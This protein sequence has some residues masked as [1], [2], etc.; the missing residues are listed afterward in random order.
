MIVGLF[1]RLGVCFNF[2]KLLV[3]IT[4]N[5]AIVPLFFLLVKF[6][7]HKGFTFRN[8]HWMF[9]FVLFCFSLSFPFAFQFE[10]LLL[11]Y[12]QTHWDFPR[13]C[14]VYWWA[15]H[16]YCWFL[17][18]HFWFLAF[19]L[20]SFLHFHLLT[21][22]SH[23]SCMLPTFSARVLTVRIM[24]ILNFLS[25]HSKPCIM[26]EAR[27]DALLA[28]SGLCFP[29]PFSVFWIFCWKPGII[30]GITETKV[31]RTSGWGIIWS[32][33]GV[34][35]CL[36]FVVDIGAGSFKF[37]LYPCLSFLLSLGFPKKHALGTVCIPQLFQLSSIVITG[38]PCGCSSIEWKGEAV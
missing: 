23:L 22:I 9:C 32:W 33:P 14:P 38:E 8:C 20:D 2:R 16:R 37:L 17:W 34:G 19:P 4:S 31:N 26:P 7:L 6:Q 30:Y 10:K 18:L 5:I 13:P 29:L 35:L 1:L 11:I 25:H 15:H 3:I 27:S 28:F 24:V 36:L 21:H 12:L